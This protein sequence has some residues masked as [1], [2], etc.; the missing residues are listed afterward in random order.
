[1]IMN[2]YGIGDILECIVTGIANYGIFVQVDDVYNGLIHIS[3]ISNHYVKNITDYVTV[4]EN[5]LCE[6]IEVDKN[7][8]HL[9]LSIKNINY[10]LIPKYGKIQDTKN[11]FK[12]LQ[13]KLPV[14]VREKLAEIKK[15]EIQVM[16]IENN[17]V[18]LRQKS[19]PVDIKNDKGLCHDIAILE[20][21]CKENE[22]MAMAA[23][24][25]CIPK[26][27]IYLKN[28]NL[29]IIDKI[30]K[31][32]ELSKEER[33][34]NEARVLINPVIKNRRG[35]TEYWEACVSC[36]DNCG[37]VL[38]PYAIDL[39]YYDVEGIKY[40]ET[41]LG[42]SS[43]VLS[44]EFD[45]LDGILHIDIAKE[46]YQMPEEERKV[47]RKSHGYKIYAKDGIYEDLLKNW[48]GKKIK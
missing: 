25:L 11:G 15:N 21:F 16:T 34:Y 45:H 28:T 41:F 1:M 5:I 14:W 29:D 36:L 8:R 33:T 47:W 10:K 23:V 27:L 42:F 9:K 31:N 6:V 4:G 2:E 43:T 37:L 13:M 24:Q 12:P 18:Y 32:D 20:E 22:V 38:R 40:L 19:K 35:L 46:L 48:N 7:E 39:E 30:Q 44:H 26:R 17:E 3:E